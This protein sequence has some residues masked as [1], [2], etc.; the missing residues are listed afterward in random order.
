MTYQAKVINGGK[1]VIP[2][3]LRRAAGIR[4]GDVVVFDTDEA[5]NIV[6]KTRT[7]VVREVQAAFRAMREPGVA[8]GVVDELIAERRAEAARETGG[9]A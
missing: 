2:A 7:Q 4:E 5:G 3:D 6:L 9:S 1:V 8:Y